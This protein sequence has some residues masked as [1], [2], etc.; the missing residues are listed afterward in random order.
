M[1]EIIHGRNGLG[2]SPRYIGWMAHRRTPP[3]NTRTFRVCPFPLSLSI[4]SLSLCLSSTVYSVFSQ[5]WLRRE[6]WERLRMQLQRATICRI[7]QADSRGRPGTSLFPGVQNTMQSKTCL[8]FRQERLLSPPVPL[9][10][11]FFVRL[12]RLLSVTG[13]HHAPRSIPRFD[14]T[15]WRNKFRRVP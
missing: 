6:P 10:F 1:P 12:F 15:K 7:F 3:Y 8:I 14:T 2:F 4:I 9:L 11:L 5:P 13:T